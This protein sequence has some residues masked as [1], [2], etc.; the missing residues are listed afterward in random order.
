MNDAID[1]IAK[2]LSPHPEVV[3]KHKR[4]QA[5]QKQLVGQKRSHPESLSN[6]DNISPA[7]RKQVCSGQLAVP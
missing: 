5:S 1:Q 6:E 2:S 4:K 3:L 7:T